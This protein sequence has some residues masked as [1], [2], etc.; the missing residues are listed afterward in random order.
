M[1]HL[2]RFLGMG[3]TV[4]F[5]LA[6]STNAHADVECGDDTAIAA[7]TSFAGG[8]LFA[9]TALPI[10][11]VSGGELDVA[12]GAFWA[13]SYGVGASGEMHLTAHNPE[14]TVGFRM[15]WLASHA[16]G[17]CRL[18]GQGSTVAMLNIALAYDEDT[19]VFL[20]IGGMFGLSSEGFGP[21]FGASIDLQARFALGEDLALETGV[22]YLPHFGTR[23]DFLN[24]VRATL[25]LRLTTWDVE[26]FV[27]VRGGVRQDRR[28]EPVGFVSGQVGV[29]FTF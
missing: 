21:L 26:P 17:E 23:L 6:S 9:V 12:A 13:D 20:G 19:R 11:I 25:A 16:G 14:S 4:L 8:A 15:Q 27:A 1:G 18:F 10:L 2:R 28:G 29:G 22:A 24:W 3:T 7:G 5:L